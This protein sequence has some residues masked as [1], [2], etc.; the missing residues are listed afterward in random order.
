[1][2]A[3]PAILS[4]A[5]VIAYTPLDSRHTPTGAAP[6]AVHGHAL[7]PVGGLAI[8]QYEDD[9]HVYLLY[10]TPDWQV[11]TDTCHHSAEDA[12]KQAER[13]YKGVKATWLSLGQAHSSQ[14]H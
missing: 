2:N 9:P 7:G 10:C 5:R 3:P 6:H 4:N 1:M 14:P 8:G 13:E 12:R 11:I